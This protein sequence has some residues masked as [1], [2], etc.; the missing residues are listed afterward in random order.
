MNCLH[1]NTP[2]QLLVFSFILLLFSCQKEQDI[3]NR[4]LPST[5]YHPKVLTTLLWD[6]DN[7]KGADS[8]FWFQGSNGRID[9][10]SWYDTSKHKRRKILGIDRSAPGVIW[11]DDGDLWLYKARVLFLGQQPYKVEFY[12]RQ[13]GV[14]LSHSYNFMYDSRGHL[15]AYCDSSMMKENMEAYDYYYTGNYP[16]DSFY[17]M[18]VKSGYPLQ[19]NFIFDMQRGNDLSSFSFT[20]FINTVAASNLAN[21]RPTCMPRDVFDCYIW[22]ELIKPWLS[23]N[24]VTSFSVKVMYPMTVQSYDEFYEANITTNSITYSDGERTIINYYP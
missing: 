11:I 4:K 16:V 14:K 2:R 23:P 12:N 6:R 13:S 15:I 9:S 24:M 19:G 22:G 5:V 17:T 1:L 3:I 10:A 21:R 7:Q 18:S 20:P 8:I